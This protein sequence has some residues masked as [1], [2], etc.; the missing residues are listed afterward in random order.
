MTNKDKHLFFKSL[1]RDGFILNKYYFIN[2][3][4]SVNISEN[5]ITVVTSNLDIN[6]F[7]FL[8]YETLHEWLNL[9]VCDEKSAIFEWL[10]KKYY[11]HDT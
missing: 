6:L 3:K 8:Q 1:I 2:K 10:H 9:D 7:Y 11:I 4:N 5:Y